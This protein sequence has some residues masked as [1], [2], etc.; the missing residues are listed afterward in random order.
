[1]IP[2]PMLPAPAEDQT[3]VTDTESAFYLHIEVA[4]RPGVLAQVA[5]I[6][7]LQGVSVKSVVQK[8]LGDDARLEMVLHPVLESK[9]KAAVDLIGRLDFLRSPPRWIRVI[10]EIF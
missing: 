6:L 8:G 5:E 3:L 4:D 1:M 9:F 10:E 2:P 7:G